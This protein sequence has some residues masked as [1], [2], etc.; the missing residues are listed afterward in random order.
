M[1]NY[2][3]ST[4]V[5][6]PPHL[7][8][9]KCSG[10]AFSDITY[11][12][13]YEEP[14]SEKSINFLAPLPY[15]ASPVLP[16]PGQKPSSTTTYDIIR[17]G[18]EGVLG[19][20]VA[21]L[22][23]VTTNIDIGDGCPVPSG[24][25]I[26][27]DIRRFIKSINF[28]ASL[29]YRSDLIDRETAIARSGW[30]E[31]VF[32]PQPNRTFD[33]LRF[34]TRAFELSLNTVNGHAELYENDASNFYNALAAQLK[35]TTTGGY[36]KLYSATQQGLWQEFWTWKD[37][38]AVVLGTS[39]GADLSQVYDS[40]D[41]TLKVPN[42]SRMM[43]KLDIT[44]GTKYG[45]LG[46]DFIVEFAVNGSTEWTEAPVNPVYSNALGADVDLPANTTSV[47]FRI[48]ANNKNALKISSIGFMTQ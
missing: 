41:Q 11:P 17:A 7:G 47:R 12:C 33:Q 24:F 1:W 2:P 4:Y 38:T 18:T 34:G 6:P 20:S 43:I 15:I 8:F 29:S 40:G 35:G 3:N 48:R 28:S 13:F 45:T 9:A 26:S 21:G 32:Q 44:Q 36:W 5:T 23:D 27:T 31:I 30:P 22:I 19:N 14:R 10:S 25:K 37:F 42:S 46:T 39:L 16:A